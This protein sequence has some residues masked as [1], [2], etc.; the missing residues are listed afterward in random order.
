[1]VLG[2]IASSYDRTYPQTVT[3]NNR[4]DSSYESKSENLTTTDNTP[5]NAEEKTNAGENDITDCGQFIQEYIEELYVKIQN[6]D[7]ETKFQTG[8]ESLTEKEWNQM[9]ERFDSQE[10][11]I[12]KAV[13]D[14]AAETSAERI[15][16]DNSYY[17]IKK[18]KDNTINI[19]DKA[20]G[21]SYTFDERYLSIQTDA[22]TG[23]QFLISD[24]PYTTMNVSAMKLT[25]KLKMAID[26]YRNGDAITE[27]ALDSKFTL[28]TDATTGIQA[29]HWRSGD[30]EA[31]VMMMSTAKQKEKFDQLANIYLTQYPNLVSDQQGA[32]IRAAEEVKGNARRT[33]GGIIT[34]TGNAVVYDDN[35]DYGMNPPDFSHCWTYFFNTDM[36]DSDYMDFISDLRETMLS[37]DTETLESEK[38]F[39]EMLARHQQ[40]RADE[41]EKIQSELLTSESLLA[42]STAESGTK[43]LHIM[44]MTEEGIFCRKQGQTSGYEWMI[45]FDFEDQYKRI[46]ELFESIDDENMPEDI[47]TREFWEKYLTED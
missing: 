20:T 46:K 41:S 22:G 4:T 21:V 28:T 26:E 36:S 3:K 35:N 19:Y 31:S 25:P 5:D 47:S 10:D 44:W 42:E 7:T 34:I 15:D 11:S 6:G 45:P 24:I 14:A 17:T 18:G 32:Q 30:T 38:D 16:V 39:M 43:E 8:N 37:A 13:T 40:A 29:L 23:D 2:G 27:K 1:M 33:P 9:L 12:K